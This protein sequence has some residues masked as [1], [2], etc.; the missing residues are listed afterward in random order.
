MCE[1]TGIPLQVHV[2]ARAR[3]RLVA[4]GLEEVGGERELHVLAEQ[5]DALPP[6]EIKGI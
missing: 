3:K 6:A 1:G 4:E 5:H 2:A